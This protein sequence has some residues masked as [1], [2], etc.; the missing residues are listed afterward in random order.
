[1][2]PDRVV[3]TPPA[4]ND[5]LG[6]AR[7]V[8]VSTIEQF[9]AQ[10]CVEALDVLSRAAR[11]DIG[12]ARNLTHHY[13]TIIFATMTPLSPNRA[14][15]DAAFRAHRARRRLGSHDPPLGR[16]SCRTHAALMP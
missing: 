1:V 4:L 12:S 16:S 10:A 13:D 8:E 11:L 15:C 14:R 3:V 9:I 7:R 2:R 6:L 5:D